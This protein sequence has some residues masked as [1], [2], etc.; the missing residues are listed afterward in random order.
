M[1]VQT[2]VV[3][4]LVNVLVLIRGALVAAWRKVTMLSA[5]TS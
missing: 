2:L 3:F 5:Q 1:A 4:S